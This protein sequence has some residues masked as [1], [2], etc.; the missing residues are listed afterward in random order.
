M[1]QKPVLLLLFSDHSVIVD[2]ND[3]SSRRRL[4][5]AARDFFATTIQRRT[6][7]PRRE[8]PLTESTLN[9]VRTLAEHLLPDWEIRSV[10]VSDLPRE[11]F[12]A[13]LTARIQRTLKELTKEGKHV[14]VAIADI[15]YHPQKEA[16]QW[17][18]A[19]LRRI[20]DHSPESRRLLVATLP[21]DPPATR[22]TD[23]GEAAAGCDNDEVV[24]DPESFHDFITLAANWANPWDEL[25]NQLKDAESRD[26]FGKCRERVAH[27]ITGPVEPLELNDHNRRVPFRQCVD[28]DETN[29]VQWERVSF[30]VVDHTS[31]HDLKA[32]RVTLDVAGR[33]S[34]DDLSWDNVEFDD[35]VIIRNLRGELRLN[36]CRF[37]QPLIIEE[38]DLERIDIRNCCFQR[39]VL[40]RR[41]RVKQIFRLVHSVFSRH[42]NL[43][44]LRI[45][46]DCLISYNRFVSYLPWFS[47]IW[48]LGRLTFQSN[49]PTFAP[50]PPTMRHADDQSTGEDSPRLL[51][52]QMF[53]RCR[54]ESRTN[55]M[56]SERRAKLC[57]YSC[58]FESGRYV[59]IGFSYLPGQSTPFDTSEPRF[60][61]PVTGAVD[62]EEDFGRHS[63]EIRLTNCNVGGRVVI[64]ENPWRAEFY[65]R[66]TGVGID[67][68]GSTVSGV[69]DLERI[70]IRWLD[71]ERASFP[72]GEVLMTVGGMIDDPT[73]WGRFMPWKVP[74]TE[75]G[76]VL[77][78]RQRH[79]LEPP[80]FSAFI[81]H[82]SRMDE[83]RHPQARKQAGLRRIAQQY[84]ELRNAF[85]RSPNTDPHEDY[86]HFKAM[87]YES[88]AWHT[89]QPLWRGM[90]FLTVTAALVL[91]FIFG[92][93]AYDLPLRS[94]WVLLPVVGALLTSY[95]VFRSVQ[96]LVYRVF[97]RAAFR[98]I[99]GYG[100]YP[101]RPLVSG[102]FI[103]M[104]FAAAYWFPSEYG[105]DGCGMIK[106]EV[107]AK[108]VNIAHD[109]ESDLLQFVYFSAVT[110][111]T[112][113]Y[114]DYK[115]TGWLEI[116]AAVEAFIGAVM[117][118]VVTISIARQFLRR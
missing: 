74:A 55:F 72:S 91:A 69:I 94:P 67:L 40:I 86:C 87:D 47:R 45:E 44:R 114:G 71:L 56:L 6:L 42:C 82:V 80:Q 64:Q 15:W 18:R 93:R 117:I 89:G 61:D 96:R 58:V 81:R 1:Q 5:R 107:G 11:N 36:G 20:R 35:A 65:A 95:V 106:T 83:F 110:F 23:C 39:E 25:F 60:C 78:E 12:E 54:F 111:T 104:L 43:A 9:V 38:C 3:P 50:V 19:A 109:N 63:V 103:V 84:E 85:A 112:L 115:P 53:H 22:W 76:I 92:C 75:C 118:A 101:H 97:D 10:K 27:R 4:L 49:E 33:T 77:E 99:V 51:A 116:V 2:D 31:T 66:E 98:W 90:A 37:N 79:D 14:N 68:S 28:P 24:F 48:F 46:G 102:P 52:A 100:V 88:R 7:P 16:S 34:G 70:R 57:F 41:C 73:V 59:E 113:G 30:D 62:E 105:W 108:D 13:G 21:E 17:G 8:T 29:D 26:I 32:D